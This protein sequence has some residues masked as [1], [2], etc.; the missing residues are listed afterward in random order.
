M[1]AYFLTTWV[2]VAS[3]ASKPKILIN[4]EDAPAIW[5]A[6]PKH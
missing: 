4:V 5:L 2:C 6:H 3:E 1:S